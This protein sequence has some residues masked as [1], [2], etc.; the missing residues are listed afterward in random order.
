MTSNEDEAE[1]KYDI[2]ISFLVQ[3]LPL[4]QALYE[5]LSEDL[6]VFFFPHNQEELAGTDGLESMHEPFFRES[7]INLVLYR[8]L[9]GNTPW[10]RVEATAIKE[11]CLDQGWD[12][13]FFFMVDPASNPPRWLPRTHVRFNHGDFSLEQ[14]VGAIKARVQEQGGRFHPLTPLRKAEL[15]RADEAYRADRSMLSSAF[16]ITA[17]H[18]EVKTLFAAVD[19]HCQAICEQNL[20]DVRC[21][22]SFQQGHATQG[23]VITGDSDGMTLNWHQPY[24]NGLDRSV[25][26]VEEYASN[27]I[28]PSEVGQLR[29]WDPPKV[30][31]SQRYHP[32]LSRARQYGWALEGKEGFLS[33]SGLAERCMIQFVDSVNRRAEKRARGRA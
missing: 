30:A 17:I 31:T 28:L 16:G 19:A 14:A 10:T 8:E 27:L 22:W 13:L 4:A 7:R 9:W 21:E 33:S 26:K 1:K 11:A 12:G 15:Y 5:G 29:Y 32:D 24:G 23:C 6:D 2:A 3:D 25:L 20:L 18:A